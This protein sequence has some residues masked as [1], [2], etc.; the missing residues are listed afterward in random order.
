M[1]IYSVRK[2]HP[3]H[4]SWFFMICTVIPSLF[5]ALPHAFS[6]SLRNMSH[7]QK[8]STSIKI[9]MFIIWENALKDLGVLDIISIG[10]RQTKTIT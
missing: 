3:M 1:K 2:Q 5:D 10:W 9:K 4:G 7:Q 6:T 8:S